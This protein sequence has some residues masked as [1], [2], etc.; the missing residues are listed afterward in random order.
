MFLG[1]MLLTFGAIGE[2][3]LGNTFPAVVFFTFGG[4]WFSFGGTLMPFFAAISSYTPEGAPADAVDGFFNSFAFFL[5]FMAVLCFI[6]MIC[7]LRTNVI[8]VFILF[9][10]CFTFPLLSASYWYLTAGHVA[11]ATNC[12]IAG[13]AF[14]FIAS[15]AGWYLWTVRLACILCYILTLLMTFSGPALRVGRLP[16]QPSHL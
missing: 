13:G 16:H 15:M 12:R 6:Y 11:Y 2:W 10:F 9:C 5:L 3:I 1:G 7:A 4:F 8:L 14:A